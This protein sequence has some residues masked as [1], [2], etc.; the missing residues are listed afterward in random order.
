MQAQV[1]T[2]T[3][4]VPAFYRNFEASQSVQEL[5]LPAHSLHLLLQGSQEDPDEVVSRYK[6]LGQTQVEPERVKATPLVVPQ[7][8]QVLALPEHVL[9]R[10]LQGGHTAVLAS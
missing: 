5:E 8:V 10:A 6:P 4:P 9:Q 1:K 3:D 7:E 2:P